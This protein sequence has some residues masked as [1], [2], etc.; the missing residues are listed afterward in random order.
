MSLKLRLCAVVL[1]AALIGGLASAAAPQ[2]IAN[3]TQED[4]FGPDSSRRIEACTRLL[5]LPLLPDERSYAFAMRAL[6]YALQGKYDLAISDYD[7]AIELSPNFAV[8]LNNRAW[9]Y[10]KSGNIRK[11]E[12]DV[13]RALDLTPESPHALDTRAH[14]RQSLGDP[15]GALADYN[16]AMRFGG[17]RMVRLYQC[18][19]QAQ[20]LYRGPLSGVINED[21]R[22]ALETCVKDTGCDPLPADEECRRLTS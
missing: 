11:A 17:A 16:A 7:E 18:G 19:L 13:A 2:A 1:S 22:G 15:T 12:V 5:D 21:M 14:V 3:T 8:A 6:S 20:G 9:A 10:F 4:C